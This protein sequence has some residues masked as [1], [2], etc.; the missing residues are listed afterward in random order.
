MP[1]KS[2]QLGEVTEALAATLRRGLPVR[3][4]AVAPVLLGLRGVSARAVDPADEASRVAALDGVLR[5]LLARFPD[6]RY[7]PAARVLFGLAPAEPG[8]TLT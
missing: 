5:G 3:P 6:G 4:A 7:A 2:P 8:S 1:T